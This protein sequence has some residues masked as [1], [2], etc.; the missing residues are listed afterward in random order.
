MNLRPLLSAAA[1]AAGLLL[2]ACSGP[3]PDDSKVVARVGDTVITENDYADYLQARQM[4][5]PPIRDPQREREVVLD[6]MINRVLLVNSAVANKVDQELDVYLQLKRQR[7]S[8]LA[9]AMLRRH[10]RDHPV[11]DEEVQKR[12]EELAAKADRNEY[13]ARHILVETEA[14]ARALLERLRK[15]AN[16]A[17]LAREHSI[18][19]GT[20][21]RG[22]ELGDWFSQDQVVPEFYAAVHSLKPGELAREPVQSEFGWHVIRL[23]GVRPRTLPDFEQSKANVR[24]LIQQE[25]VE[26]L[27]QSL[28]DQTRI[29]IE[30]PGGTPATGTAR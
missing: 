2:G 10:L 13:R 18:D 3:G 20:G 21:R 12:Y 4:Q 19:T 16:F 1:L 7:E 22:G 23:D 6:E 26:A 11:T 24:Q 17:N 29:K 25:R 15:G 30:P 5:H 28:K 27:L 9:R 14:E 8:V